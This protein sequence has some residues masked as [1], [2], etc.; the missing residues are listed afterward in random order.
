MKLWKRTLLCLCLISMLAQQVSANAVLAPV[1]NYVVNRAVAGI[2]ANRIAAAEGIAANDAVWLAR[3]AN[4]PVFAATMAG[5]SKQMTAVNVAS[6]V[7]AGALA[8]AGAPV[9]LTIAAGLG[10]TALG[11]YYFT[12]DALQKVSINQS[13]SSVV[14]QTESTPIKPAY[15]PPAS[16]GSS[17]SFGAMALAS[18]LLVYRGSCSNGG[19]CLSY[20][21]AP[22]EYWVDAP[23]M[24]SNGNFVVI[25]YTLSEVSRFMKAD[26]KRISDGGGYDGYSGQRV[27]KSFNGAF[28][29]L[30]SGG[31]QDLFGTYTVSTT[32]PPVKN[33][34]GVEIVGMP[35]ITTETKQLFDW[36]VGTNAPIPQTY[37]NLTDAYPNLTEAQKAIPVPASQ[38]AEIT[39]EAWLRAA[40]DSNYKG[41]PYSVTQPITTADVATWQAANPNAMPTLGDMLRPARNPATDPNGVPISPTAN[42]NSNPIPNP[43]PG[44]NP[45][46]NPS[47]R[48]DLGEDPGVPDPTL[49][50]T[51]DA[52]TILSPLTSL[53]PELR[54]YQA[55]SH[56]SQCPKPTF[57][58]FGRSIVMDAQ[59]TI[60]EQFRSELAAVMLVV[61][62]LVGLFILLSA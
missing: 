32:P 7:A 41:L 51:P 61:W 48:P 43:N 25:A 39:N 3:A 31:G 55:P 42:S 34:S 59:C 4:E 44:T 12:N 57:D 15:I 23:L 52:A 37:T 40:Q 50:D 17:E 8:I 47:G 2:V 35:V 36:T 60:A 53:F 49:E 56:V 29:L 19:D 33:A 45:G 58:L 28:F 10:I 62:L 20:P 27:T 16:S 30:R 5:I 24:L 13:G 22:A 26:T 14:I 6:T 38:L 46:T 54:S 18:G 11:A 21:P 9:W 1:E